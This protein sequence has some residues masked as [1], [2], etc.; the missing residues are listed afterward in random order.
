MVKK[1]GKIY[2]DLLKDNGEFFSYQEFLER[3][4]EQTN[5]LQYVGIIQAIKAYIKKK[6]NW[7]YKKKISEP[8][9]TCS[10]FLYNEKQTRGQ[11]YVWYI[12]Y[13]LG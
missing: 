5:F 10:L 1:W 12:K 11:D 13:K 7:Y 4:R 8:F 6:N 3:A 2:Q 9:Y